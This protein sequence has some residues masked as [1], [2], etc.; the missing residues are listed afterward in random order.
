MRGLLRRGV[1]VVVGGS[2]IG[3]ALVVVLTT[4]ASAQVRAPGG[5]TVYD[6]TGCT[7]SGNAPQVTP[8]FSVLITGLTPNSTT[9]QLYVTSKDT[10][11]EVTYGPYII[12]NVDSHGVSCL[13][14]N[15]APAGTWKI[16]VVEEGSGFTNSK[17][18]TVLPTTPTTTTTI[19]PPPPPPTTVAPTTVAPTT[20]TVAPTTTTV[21]PTTTTPGS[22]T[23]GPTTVPPP[24]PPPTT[25]V[26]PTTVPPPS[27]T[28]PPV[29]FPWNIDPVTPPDDV[30]AVLP[31]T[32]SSLGLGLAVA[33]A[34][35]GVGAVAVVLARRSRAA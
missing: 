2:L 12:P 24:P 7:G 3:F 10:N 25:A 22:T 17:V 4:S 18:I 14:V 26:T 30:P 31:A 23:T 34:A 28:P 13:N 29:P 20:T 11:P 27:T 5:V 6:A 35:I 33:V 32:G 15:Q 1:D 9:S 8:P 16:D 19:A 21:G